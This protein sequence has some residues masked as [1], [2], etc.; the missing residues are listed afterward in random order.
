[1]Q[2]QCHQLCPVLPAMTLTM[3]LKFFRGRSRT[4]TWSND[5]KWKVV[6]CFRSHRV[7]LW[8]SKPRINPLCFG[9]RTKWIQAG[10]GVAGGVQRTENQWGSSENSSSRWLSKNVAVLRSQPWL[11]GLG[12]SSALERNCQ[13]GS[14]ISAC[15]TAGRGVFC[16][17]E[18][19][20][21]TDSRKCE[22]AHSVSCRC[23]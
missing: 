14:Q 3:H 8:A 4:I 13:F 15:A 10:D 18:Q 1:M 22:N 21:K 5:F 11:P 7:L 9:H 20:T 23:F 12:A 16:L 2:S 6:D 19:V 17:E